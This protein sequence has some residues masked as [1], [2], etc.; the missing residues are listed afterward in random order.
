MRTILWI[1]IRG[2]RKLSLWLKKKINL[3]FS[4]LAT[5]PATGAM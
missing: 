2:E 1:G 5:L 3:S 4:A